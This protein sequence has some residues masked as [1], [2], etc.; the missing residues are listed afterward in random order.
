MPIRKPP[1]SGQGTSGPS[2]IPI[3]LLAAGR[4]RRL[5]QS[6]PLA[7]L[8]GESL[9]ERAILK[10]RPLT[11][12]LIVVLGYQSLRVRLRCRARPHLWRVNTEWY[13]GQSSS[14]KVGLDSLGCCPKGVLI[15]LVDQPAIPAQH[16]HA[17]LSA[18]ESASGESVATLANSRPMAPA[19]LPRRL[20]PQVRRLEGDEGARQILALG[21]YRVRCDQA[22]DDIDTY[23]DLIRH[24]G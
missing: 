4:G 16:Y 6:K 23:A 10:L 14:I 21:G 11:T 1:D 9:L 7:E 19:Y 8:G 2:S 15:C 13:L 5:G 3:I 18:A 22:G 12:R 17:L 24:R 20:W